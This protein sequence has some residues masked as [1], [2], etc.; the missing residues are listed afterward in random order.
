MRDFSFSVIKDVLDLG[1]KII[2]AR[3]SGVKNVKSNHEI[4]LFIKNEL[5]KIKQQWAGKNWKEDSI[6]QGFRELHTKVGRSNKDYPA[7]PEVLIKNLLE[8][9]R[10]PRINAVVDL[11]NIVSLSTQLALGAHNIEKINGNVTLRL[12]D[13]KEKFLPLGSTDLIKVLPGEY[14]YC[15]DDNTI[16]CR[17]EV[18]Q[19]EPTKITEDATDIFFIIQGNANTTDEYVRNAAQQLREL[20]T[21]FLGGTSSL[22]ESL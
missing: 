12:T 19:V 3:I 21:R 7:S 10:F 1:V 5:E 18:L 4:D 22:L 15:N 9:D 13:G 2:T 20:I 8:R 11:Y 17:L 16:I 6:L 14:A